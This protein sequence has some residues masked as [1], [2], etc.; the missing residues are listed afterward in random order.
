MA[1]QEVVKQN[2]SGGELSDKM[3]GRWDLS[4]FQNGCRR[5]KNFIA[6]TEGGA[7]YR[8]GF[9]HVHHSRLNRVM[10]LKKF[11]FNDEQAYILEFTDKKLRFY[12]N[13]GIILESSKVISAITKAS[14]G[15]VTTATH[16]YENGDE[17]FLSEVVG[18]TEVNGKSFIVANKTATTFE[19]TDVDGNN[20]N[21]TG[22][23]T[24]SSAGVSNRVFELDTPYTD[25]IS[26][27]LTNQLFKIETDQDA[28]TMYITH[29]HYLPRK[30]TR[31][32]HTAWTLTL[33]V[34][35]ADPFTT[36][37]VITA[38]TQANPGVVTISSHTFS[39]GDV[40]V[41]E[42][43]VGMVEVNS[44]PYIVANKATNTFE[45][46]DL[47]GAN[48]DTSGFT[49]YASVG[50]AS[51]QNLIPNAVA[52]HESRLW[53]GGPEAAPDKLF[54]SQAPNS[55]GV[56]QYDDFTTGTDPEDGLAFSI[57]SS[58]VNKILWLAGTDRLLMVGTFGSEIK[59][60]GS[61]DETAITPT[62]IKARALN[63]IGVADIAPINKESFIMYVQRGEL[64]LKSLQ[65]DALKDNF[66]ATDQNL[67]SDHITQG[68]GPWSRLTASTPLTGLKQLTW[69]TGRPDIAWALRRDGILLG[70]TYKPEEGIAGWHRHTTGATGEDSFI[71]IST[72][73]R[74]SSFDQLWVGTE[75]TVNS[76]TRRY[77]GYQEDSP[78]FPQEV[79]YFTGAL[80]ET[81]DKA[82]FQAALFEAQ[83]EYVHLDNSLTYDGTGAGV[84]A[85]ATMTPGA[86]TGTSITFTAGAAV[87]TS[88]A[89]DVGREIWKRPING[90]GTGRAEITGFTNSTTVVCTILDGADFDT[91]TAMAAGDWYL[92][93]DSIS[94]LDHLEG[95]SVGVVT[96]GGIHPDLTVSSGAIALTYQASIVHVGTTYEGFLQP[97]TMEFGGETGPSISKLKVINE[98]AFRFSNSLGAEVGTDLYD[99]ETIPFTAMPLQIG[100]PQGVFSGIKK[101]KS[102][103]SY[104]RDKL[105]YV[106]QTK[107]LPCEVQQ[108]VVYGEAEEN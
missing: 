67:V 57:N 47:N 49:A 60:T 88:A 75:L 18:M 66:T 70:L 20:V 71:S 94:N 104:S 10:N 105:M 4:V 64:T 99:A 46:T 61:D 36:K 91:T 108:I 37:Q 62:S 17:V 65:F 8:N 21:T 80:N 96:D 1:E 43:V 22:F 82:Q 39:D 42:E 100:R 98:F 83:K 29:P 85:S 34:I 63:R 27:A 41:I 50:F 56:T 102:F 3:N 106:R 19:L 90:I 68:N 25:T 7:L 89:V 6:L 59:T 28:D 55:S 35:T 45:L 81:T 9:R 12:R 48:I 14:P 58:E 24:Y 32:D 26:T 77:V 40:V 44:Q 86:L 16:S 5:M 53:Y 74:P 54:A 69:Q 33:Q 2:F 97:M 52:I 72:L 84:D 103:D 79:D 30:L 13:N 51:L 76:L 78:F 73:P 11:E 38:I 92:T 31:T 93:T 23:T 15:V 107:P 101:V 95:R 87:F